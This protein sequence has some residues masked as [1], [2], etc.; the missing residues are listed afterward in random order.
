[1]QPKGLRALVIVGLIWCL[2]PQAS[3][4]LGSL[5]VAI[6]SPASGETVTG[7]TMVRA[8][9]TVI[10]FLTVGSVQFELDGANNLGEDTTAPYSTR[11]DTPP[12]GNG[13]H[14]VTAVARDRLG[15]LRFASDPVTV[16]RSK[17]S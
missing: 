16:N 4:Q 7:T 9:V 14:T 6:S 15:L 11:G 10:G 3:A 8:S 12:A 1:M 17:P 5:I 13:W 2:A